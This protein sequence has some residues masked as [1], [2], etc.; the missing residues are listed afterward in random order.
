MQAILSHYPARR[1][2]RVAAALLLAAPLLVAAAFSSELEWDLGRNEVRVY[3]AAYDLAEGVTVLGAALPSRLERLGYRR[4]HERPEVPGEYFWGNEVFWIFQRR[5]RKGRREYPPQLFGLRLEKTDG[6]ILGAVHPDGTSH[7]LERRGQLWLEPE[8]L[9]ESLDGRRARREPL[10]LAELP[11]HVWRAVLAAEDARF[12]DHVGLDGIALSRAILANVRA[13]KVSQ[14]GSTITQQLI[15]NRALSPKRSLGRKAS[16][17][18]RAL[19]LEAEHDKRDIL[20][21]YI[22]HVYMG[23]RGGLAVHGLGTAAR[24]YFSK[25]AGEITL[26]EAACLAAMIQGPNRLSPD[27]HPARLRDR[28]DRVLRRM[29][30]IGWAEPGRAAAARSEAVIARVS[31]PE[32]PPARH[33]LDWI[34]AE[35]ESRLGQRLDRGRGVVVET[36]LD[37]WLQQIAESEVERHLAALRRAFPR[38]RGEGLSAALVALDGATG[39]VMAY[40]GGDPAREGGGFDRAREAKRQ[41]GWTVKPLILLEAFDDCGPKT[42]LNAATRIADEPLQIEAPGGLWRP[43]NFD[44]RYRGV[45]DLRA[46]L[47]HSYNVPFARIGRWCGLESVARRL[48][49]AGLEVPAGPP[50]SITLGAIEASPL[51][52]A[53]AYTVFAGLGRRVEPRPIAEIAKPSGRRLERF[54][55]RSRR[56]SRRTTAWLVHEL[57][58]DA[59]ENGTGRQARIDG[60]AVAAKTGS[61]SGL[62]DAWFSGEV[63]G[64]VTTAWIGLDRDA[65]LGLTGGEASAPLWRE[66]AARAVLAIPGSEPAAPRGL[67]T[68][69][70]DPETG[71]VKSRLS[72]GG[73]EETFRRGAVP[74]SDRPLLRDEPSPVI[75]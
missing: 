60:L 14:G 46:A 51:E 6:A 24:V 30:R 61:S 35:V 33:F 53:S 49:R 12:F 3:S 25:P 45:V 38:L 31:R 71:L 62:R 57:M 40:V 42:P 63:R 4:V 44:R 70:V 48:E 39:N 36:T 65:P 55:K 41:I 66:F 17:A 64:L 37:P 7:R 19:A 58:R 11:E 16:E 43:E 10:R 5:H 50:P 27:G 8:L 56:V 47:R 26:S 69:R 32:P 52:I 34:A 67:V 9:A 29:E 13:G 28:R 59:V 15:K 54:G 68:R 22:N 1:T 2:A 73:R 21:S 20:E 75:R 72:R 74:P 18:L 23:H